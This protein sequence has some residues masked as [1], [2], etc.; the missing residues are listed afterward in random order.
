[1]DESRIFLADRSRLEMKYRLSTDGS[2]SLP[3]SWLSLVTRARVFR[4]SQPRADGTGYRLKNLLFFENL[5]Y[6][7]PVENYFCLEEYPIWR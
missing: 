3:V 1:M 4:P 5:C 7:F 2:P 6:T